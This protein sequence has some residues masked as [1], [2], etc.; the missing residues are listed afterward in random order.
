VLIALFAAAAVAA[1]P[2][3]TSVRVPGTTLRFGL[4]DSVLSARGFPLVKGARRGP[5]RFFGLV[6]EATLDVAGGRLALARFKVE[7]ASRTEIA[8]VG[9][10]LT[11]MG[12]RRHCEQ[13]EADASSCDWTGRARLEIAVSDGTLTA[14]V[15]PPPPEADAAA[16]PAPA[17]P[18]PPGPPPMA[19]DTLAV[20][21]RQE[22]G[23][24]AP[25]VARRRVAPAYPDA[26][27]EA[28]VQGRVL[29]LAT[30]DAD[31]RVTDAAILRGIRELDAAALA[32]V[33]QW[34]FEPRTWNGAPCRTRVIVPVLFTLH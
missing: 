3:D 14:T 33:R 9:D 8:Y 21:F 23:R 10:Q 17:S 27:R 16:A 13:L 6:G 30:V 11:R 34:I 26:A 5:C 2:T 28:G 29:V 4:R 12:Y 1:A 32:A 24:Y 19:P 20:P 22:L 31:G 7:N 18:R 25:A 15:T